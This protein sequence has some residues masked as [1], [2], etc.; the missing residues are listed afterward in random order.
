MDPGSWNW[1]WNWTLS[2]TGTENFDRNWTGTGT[3][4]MSRIDVIRLVMDPGTW[5]E[6]DLD[7]QLGW[8]LEL[9]RNWDWT[10]FA[11]L[12]FKMGTRDTVRDA[13]ISRQPPLLTANPRE[14]DSDWEL[15]GWNQELVSL[16]G[17]GNLSAWLDPGTCPLGWILEL[18]HLAGSWNCPLGWILELARNRNWIGTV[19]VERSRT[20]LRTTGVVHQLTQASTRMG[21]FLGVSSTGGHL[22]TG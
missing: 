2:L 11:G 15:L 18:A 22:G 20:I 10:A 9:D 21:T 4:L 12:R 6:L 14:R 1:N 17:S 16:A 3:G 19:K 8:I 5:Q 7:W 13:V